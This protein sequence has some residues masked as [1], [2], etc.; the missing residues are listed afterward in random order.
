[1]TPSNARN[2]DAIKTIT[3]KQL[4]GLGASHY[5]AAK[6][7]E[8][9]KP[10]GRQGRAYLFTINEVIHSIRSY[11]ECPRLKPETY[12]KLEKILDALLSVLGN[13][14]TAP[15]SST[16]SSST[17]QLSQRLM[18]AMAKTDASLASLKL[19]A[20]GIESKYALSGE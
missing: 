6:V 9:L 10:V 4:R 1:M 8:D 14:L 17:S 20:A 3:R 18:K 13:V 19:D 11:R 15:F 16:V 2:T 7:T 12:T 5:H